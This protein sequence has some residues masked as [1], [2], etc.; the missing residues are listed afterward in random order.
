V[1]AAQDT[2]IDFSSI[3]LNLASTMA[4]TG[5]IDEIGYDWKDIVGDV[6]SGSVT[7]IV[8]EGFNYVVR[9]ADGFYYKL[10][11][12]SFYNNDGDKGYP[13]FEYQRL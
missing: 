2:V 5:A 11:F 3:D 1:T 10:R 7:Y 12:I 6:S 9:D 8:K 13:T 4:Y